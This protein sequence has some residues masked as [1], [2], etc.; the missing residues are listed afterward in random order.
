MIWNKLDGFGPTI[1]FNF[2][3]ARELVDLAQLKTL[4]Q[5]PL[6]ENDV[7]GNTDSGD[8]PKTFASD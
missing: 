8:G 3:V 7:R 2:D 1:R 4:R 5:N 6:R